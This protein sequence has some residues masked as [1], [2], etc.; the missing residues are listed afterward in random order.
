VI[1]NKPLE[2]AGMKA[3]RP[4]DAA[5]AGRSAPGRYAAFDRAAFFAAMAAIGH[6][7]SAVTIPESCH[8][9]AASNSSR[10]SPDTDER[11]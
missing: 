11:P 5:S 9:E 8:S 4:D 6:E 7:R 3:S 2:R 10:H 1:A